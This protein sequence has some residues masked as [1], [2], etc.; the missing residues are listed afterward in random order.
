M[1]VRVKGIRGCWDKRFLNGFQG[2]K[3]NWL[4]GKRD[5]VAVLVKGTM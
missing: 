3:T 5:H 1:V 4:S 2:K